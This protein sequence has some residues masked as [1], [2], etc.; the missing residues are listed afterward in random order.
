MTDNN[1]SMVSYEQ[2]LDFIMPRTKKKITKTIIAK[3]KQTRIAL[4]NG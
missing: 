1:Q 4:E 3:I 2:F